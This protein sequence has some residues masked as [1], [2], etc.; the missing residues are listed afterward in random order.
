MLAQKP[1]RS[2]NS[3]LSGNCNAPLK[4]ALLKL[5]EFYGQINKSTVSVYQAT[6]TK[7]IIPPVAVD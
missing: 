6:G 5:S 4:V 2:L 1:L 7:M 3:I